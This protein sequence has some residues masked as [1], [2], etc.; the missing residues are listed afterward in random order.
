MSIL[1]LDGLKVTYEVYIVDSAIPTQ[2]SRKNLSQ[3]DHDFK[4]HGCHRVKLQFTQVQILNLD[5]FVTLLYCIWKL[6]WIC[7]FNLPQSFVKVR[8][9]NLYKTFI[10]PCGTQFMW[11]GKLKKRLST[12]FKTKVSYTIP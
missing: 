7:F 10:H 5:Q 9:N 4:Y 6:W 1:I 8:W 12:L 2:V 11:F 3:I